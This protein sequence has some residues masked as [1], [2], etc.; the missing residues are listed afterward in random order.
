MARGGRATCRSCGPFGPDQ[1]E[2]QEGHC[3]VAQDGINCTMITGDSPAVAAAIASVSGVDRYEAHIRPERKQEIV[4]E[5]KSGGNLVGMV[6]DGINDAPV[7][8]RGGYKD[9]HRK[10]N[11]RGQGDPARESDHQEGQAESVLGSV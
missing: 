10:R 3:T 5:Y 4:G 6:W 9:S 2:F 8:C 7:P 11:G 1:G